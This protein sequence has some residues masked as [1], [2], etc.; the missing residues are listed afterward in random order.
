V[1]LLSS[2]TASNG[3]FFFAYQ[4]NGGKPVVIDFWAPWCAPCKAISPVLEKLAVAVDNDPDVEVGFYKVNI[5]KVESV[6]LECRIA[7]VC[8]ILDGV[9]VM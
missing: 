6:A 8:R 7:V 4:V 5:D 1:I 2:S 9:E 3:E